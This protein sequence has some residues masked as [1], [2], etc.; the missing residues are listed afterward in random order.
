MPRQCWHGKAAQSLLCRA[1][2]A[3]RADPAHRKVKRGKDV[4]LEEERRDRVT[5]REQ[6]RQPN[7]L[8]KA[9]QAH[10]SRGQ[11]G[12]CSVPWDDGRLGTKRGQTL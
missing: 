6:G 10:A 2:G 9:G 3:G 1:G 5:A 11:W 7:Q 8:Q 4:D 12:S